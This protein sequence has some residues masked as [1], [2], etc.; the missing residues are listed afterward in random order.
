[1]EKND[2]VK[3]EG[4]EKKKTDEEQRWK[5]IQEGSKLELQHAAPLSFP[6]KTV[7]KQL[8]DKFLKF[9]EHMRKLK[10]K[11]S[12]LKAIEQIP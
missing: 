12:F 3:E 9:L 11:I 8:Q 7:E 2:E 5:K 1:M 4:R 10:M 6:Y